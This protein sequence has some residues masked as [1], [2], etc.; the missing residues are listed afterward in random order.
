MILE[1]VSQTLFT[2]PDGT[3]GRLVMQQGDCNAAATCQTLMNHI[4]A[5]YISVFIRSKRVVHQGLVCRAG[6]ATSLSHNQALY[7]RQ[8]DSVDISQICTF[9]LWGSVCVGSRGVG[10]LG[11]SPKGFQT[12]GCGIRVSEQLRGWVIRGVTEYLRK[13]CGG[14]GKETR[15]RQKE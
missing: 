3:M 8:V 10:I 6:V 15:E 1:H 2:S 12:A 14:W 4:F 7:D 13:W 11:E 5:S 9:A